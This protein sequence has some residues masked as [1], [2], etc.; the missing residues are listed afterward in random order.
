MQ[1]SMDEYI[2]EIRKY[3]KERIIVYGAGKIARII[4][5]L[6]EE[7]RIEIAGFC[8]TDSRNNLSHIDGIPVC[9][10][11]KLEFE[12]EHTVFL[13][14]FREMGKKTMAHELKKN[15]VK[16]VVDVPDN[17]L[18][19]DG[20][21][22]RRKERPTMEITPIIG[23]TVNCHYCP[24]Q[25]LL[26]RYFRDDKKRKRSLS[27]ED[28]KM[29]LSKLPQDTLIEFAGFVEPFLNP[30]AIDM[31]EYCFEKGYETTLFTTLVGLNREDL[32][33]VLR[34][35]FSVVCLHT[36]DS[37]GYANIPVTEEY[38]YMLDRMVNAQKTDGAPFVTTANCQGE[39]HE[40]VLSVT[41][42]KL[43]IWA[44][45]QDRAGNLSEKDETLSHADKTGE[46][47]CDRANNLDHFVLL[48][49][50]TVVLCCNDFGLKHVMGNLLEEDYE[51]ILHGD[52][53]KSI[54]RAMKI[55]ESIPLLCRKCVYAKKIEQ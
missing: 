40:K 51:Q 17:I 14:G 36:A 21:E 15:G 5:R 12:P 13:I 48:P 31:M 19:Y 6:C 4:R 25:P 16:M 29:I 3:Q 52:E 9:T 49:D 46:I 26:N 7:N 27:F 24:Q 37:A 50:G 55:E 33:R 35:P 1:L 38:L 44:E 18:E 53:M 54:K 34:L 47:C 28:F 32:E 20:W 41:E 8:V 42:G 11:E 10:F 39:P 2:S 45:L 30:E 23:C 22:Q 43:K